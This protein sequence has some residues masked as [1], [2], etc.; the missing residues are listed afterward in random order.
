MT[1]RRKLAALQPGEGG[2]VVEIGGD[3]DAVQRL[4]IARDRTLADA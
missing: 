2:R 4:S 3:G 1:E